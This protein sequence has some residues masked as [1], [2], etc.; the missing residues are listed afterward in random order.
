MKTIS[1]KK[2]KPSKSTSVSSCSATAALLFAKRCA[3]SARK[4]TMLPPTTT[5][6]AN[7][8]I[9]D[10]LKNSLPNSGFPMPIK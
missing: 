7:S 5:E 9:I 10:I 4:H 3:M 1:M 6:H 8:P 2:H